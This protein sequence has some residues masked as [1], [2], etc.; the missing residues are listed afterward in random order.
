MF[1][2]FHQNNS[3]GVFTIDDEDGIGPRVWIEANSLAAAIDRALAIGIYFDG[4]RDGI[5]C[6]CC[7]D[8]WS[9]PWKDEGE[10][11]PEIDTKY[12]FDWHDTVYVH[13]LDK[14]IERIKKEAE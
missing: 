6:G 4:V 2:L 10:N 9:E 14:S 7:G 11:Q 5:D 3:G 13:R 12:D 1:Y 8:R